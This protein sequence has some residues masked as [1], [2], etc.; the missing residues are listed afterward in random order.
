MSHLTRVRVPRAGYWTDAGGYYYQN[1][2]PFANYEQALLAVKADAQARSIPFRYAQFDDWWAVQRGDFG[3]DEGPLHLPPGPGGGLMYWQPRNGTFPSGLTGWLGWPLSLYAPA[4][5]AKSLYL[6]VSRYVDSTS[7][8]YCAEMLKGIQHFDTF[9]ILGVLLGL[10]LFS[11]S[12]LLPPPSSSFHP[13]FPF[14]LWYLP[15]MS[16]RWT[17]SHC[18]RCQPTGGSTTSCLR[19]VLVPA[20]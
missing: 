4:Y 1:P 12:P 13:S 5:S 9:Y 8:L 2:A 3:G 20:W 16:G 11:P 19:T 15:G 7:L 17:T 10:L 14:L 6:N 18:T